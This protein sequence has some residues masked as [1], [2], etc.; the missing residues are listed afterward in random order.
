MTILELREKK[1]NLSEE[2]SN[3]IKLGESEKRE[4][5]DTETARMAEI[6]SEI[7]QVEK[8]IEAVEAENRNIANKNQKTENKMEKEI[9]LYDLIKG[10]A[11]NTLTDEQRAFVKNGNTINYRADIV[12]GTATQ[13]QENVAEEKK[14]LDVAIRNASVLSKMGATWFSN[15][16]GDIS[17]PRYSGSNVGWKGEVAAADDGA[18]N[19]SETML[20]PLRLTAY[21]DVSRTF[22]A[23]DSNDAEAILIADLAE[24]I[25]EKLDMTIFGDGAAEEGVKPAGLFAGNYVTTGTTL[26]DL[27]Y[28]DVLGLEETV[29]EKNGTN[30]IFIAHP[31]VKYA[32]KGTQMAHGL[33]MVFN[34]GEIDGYK[35]I[36]SN[37]VKEGGVI[38]MDPRD[39]AVATWNGVEVQV[40]TV[41]QAINSKVRLIVNFF[42]DVKLRGERIAAGIFNK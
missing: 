31:T 29:E 10:V 36:V 6:R 34:A 13:G 17:I 9:R 7:E 1:L 35:T 28:D 16:V 25:A 27:G 12:A 38:A 5:A 2:L 22:L 21:V 42:V 3:I 23:Q 37:S 14:S 32:L 26:S 40:D 39:L 33:Q 18:G 24:A 15:A 4:L 8:D 30:F 19:F 20:K 41:T 11:N